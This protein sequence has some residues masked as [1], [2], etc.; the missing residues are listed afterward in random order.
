MVLNKSHH[1]ASNA[2]SAKINAVT[3]I[4]LTFIQFY[5]KV[6]AIIEGLK[7]LSGADFIQLL[8]FF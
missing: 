1:G 2:N 3:P 5:M 7:K 8:N 4:F 6:G